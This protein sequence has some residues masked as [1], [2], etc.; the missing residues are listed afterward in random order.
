MGQQVRQYIDSLR[1]STTATI[2]TCGRTM[3]RWGWQFASS[4]QLNQASFFGASGTA[5]DDAMVACWSANPP[6]M[7]AEFRDVR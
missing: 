2:A 3:H 1:K 5:W 4:Q 7:D 6:K